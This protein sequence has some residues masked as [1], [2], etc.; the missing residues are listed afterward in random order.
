MVLRNRINSRT[1]FDGSMIVAA[2]GRTTA[3]V[4]GARSPVGGVT[5][6][7]APAGV[8]R[9]VTTMMCRSGVSGLSV[10]VVN[11]D[12]LLFAG[13]YGLADRAANGPAT[14]STAYLWF[15][16]TKIVTATAA[17]RLA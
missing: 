1:G 3:G 10:A 14:A 9:A 2:G 17:L 16:M 4:V 6:V 13:G 7:P 5:V 15:S 11:R 12:R 8:V